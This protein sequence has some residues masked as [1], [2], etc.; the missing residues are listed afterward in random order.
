MDKEKG[1]RGT[2]S[3]SEER[4]G[5]ANMEVGGQEVDPDPE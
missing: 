1:G 2:E 3:Y 5:K 4:G